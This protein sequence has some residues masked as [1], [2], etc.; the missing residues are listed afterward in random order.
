MALWHQ[1]EVPYI[2]ERMIGFSVP[3]D[4]KVLVVSYEGMHIV[5][6]SK[7]ITVSTDNDY[8]EYDCYDPD[9]GIAKYADRE[10]QI[11][12]LFPGAPLT[13][14]PNGDT[15][16]LDQPSLSVSVIRDGAPIWSEIYENFSGDWAAATFSDDDWYI[17]LGCPYDFDFRVWERLPNV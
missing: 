10:W 11:I 6:L 9:T 16:V 17:V 4:R 7:P 14:R 5:N 12:G 1:L 15:L 3:Q 8:A 13:T 2:C